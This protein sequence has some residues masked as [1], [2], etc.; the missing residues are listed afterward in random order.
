MAEKRPENWP[1]RIDVIEFLNEKSQKG[2]TY[3]LDHE[4]KMCAS[5]GTRVDPP[6]DTHEAFV[7]LR[8]IEEEKVECDH[9]MY[10]TK[11]LPGDMVKFGDRLETQFNNFC[12]EC[13]EELK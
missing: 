6:S 7:F 8:E 9:E 10:R 12:P 1:A 2:F 11:T 4:D 13:G 5:I 3:P